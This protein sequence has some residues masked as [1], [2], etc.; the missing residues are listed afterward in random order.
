MSALRRRTLDELR[1]WLQDLPRCDRAAALAALERDE[2]Q[3]ARDLAARW[4]RSRQELAS[5]LQR[6]RRLRRL[7]LL[8]R[9]EGARYVAGLDEAGRGPLAGPVV[10]AAVM[11]P[12]RCRLVGLDDSKRLA[13]TRREELYRRLVEE[14]VAFGLGVATVEEIERLNIARA[15]FAAM[16]RAVE[17][18]CP[19][20]DFVLVD[21]FT[22]PGLGLPQQGVPGGD[23]RS[24]AIAAASVVAKVSRDRMMEELDL[25]YPQ[26]GFARH[27][28]YA[29]REHLRALGLW[30]PCPEH[31]RSFLRGLRWD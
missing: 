28:G 26:Y 13:P 15:A 20:P 7:E 25:R 3:G 10:A 30:G 22:V 9:R 31:R 17:A 18:L 21:G 4:R 19:A 8:A 2:R 5:E 14:G 27:K 23:G 6:L 12:L 11:L 16:R 29:T 24:L 1:R